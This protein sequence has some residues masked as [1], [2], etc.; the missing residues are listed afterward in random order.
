VSRRPCRPA[1][2]DEP[3]DA[4]HQFPVTS[5]EK[6]PLPVY[7]N[8]V[9]AEGQNRKRRI[10]VFLSTTLFKLRAAGNRALWFLAPAAPVKTQTVPESMLILTTA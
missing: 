7:S 8:V 3:V 9:K 10:E 4:D 1:R 2:N 6:C 5:K